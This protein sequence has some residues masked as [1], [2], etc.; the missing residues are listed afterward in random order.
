MRAL[1]RVEY[2]CART[3]A[4]KE[5]AY[6]LRYEAY[7]RQGLIASRADGMLYDKGVDDAPNA[8]ITTMFIDGE[9]ASTVRIHVADR[10][11]AAIPS[12]DPFSDLIMPHL[13]A[14]RMI[15]D[16]TRLAA[17]LEFARRFPELP[18]L[19]L[20]PGWMAGEHFGADFGIVSVVGQ[21]QAFYRRVFGYA[22]WCEPRDYPGF[23]LK[24]ACMGLDFRAAKERV[25]ARHPAFRSTNA[26]R[27]ILFGRHESR[28]R[29]R[30]SGGSVGLL[31]ACAGPP[32]E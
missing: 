26:E 27:E 30:V 32:R 3:N 4:E 9:L 5:A 8:W 11:S 28:P 22:P 19:A 20:R 2:R 16:P 17:E 6:R 23:N 15:V 31:S 21:H 14:G 18:Y 12:V 10:A 1:E 13:N 25:E 24:V 29:H 7:I